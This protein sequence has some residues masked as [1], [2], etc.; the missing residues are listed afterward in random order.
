[1]WPSES[2]ALNA[3]I[4]FLRGHDPCL[5]GMTHGKAF[6]NK[7]SDFET[8]KQMLCGRLILTLLF[9]RVRQCVGWQKRSDASEQNC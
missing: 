2:C 6:P 5:Q 8:R 9:F 3:M 1:M 7:I 4:M